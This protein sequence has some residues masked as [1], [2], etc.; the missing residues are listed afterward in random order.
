MV[1]FFSALMLLSVCKEKE[2]ITIPLISWEEEC[3]QA[4][5]DPSRA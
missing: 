2:V 5:T 4:T 1:E 3:G